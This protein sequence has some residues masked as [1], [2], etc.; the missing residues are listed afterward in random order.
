MSS[1]SISSRSLTW[2]STA[3][4]AALAAALAGGIVAAGPASAVPIDRPLIDTAKFDLGGAFAPGG[5]TTGARL[6]WKITGGVVRP[7][8]TGNFR[9]KNGTCGKVRMV[10]YRPNHTVL[11]ARETNVVC[12][13]TTT[14]IRIDNFAHPQAQHVHINLDRRN[15]NGT[16]TT[17]GTSVENL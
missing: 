9:V 15:N 14:P 3:T 12:G 8:L 11:A 4:A 16:F 13:Q 7:E 17:V 6:E 10:Y 1:I 2:R 5:P